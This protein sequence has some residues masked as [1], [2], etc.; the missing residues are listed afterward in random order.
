MMFRLLLLVLWSWVVS[1]TAAQ[2]PNV[3]FI[4]VD[5]LG[6]RDLGYMGSSYYETPNID[7]LAQEGMVFTQAYAGAANC[8]P[9]RACLLSGMNTPRHGIYTVGNSDRGDTRTRKVIPASNQTVLADSIYTLAELFRGQGYVTGTFGKWHLGDNPTTQGFDVNAGGSH[10]GNPGKNGYF[11]PY[12]VDHLPD[13]PEGEYLTDRLTSEAIGFLQANQE[14]P[15]FLYLPYYT[16]H[17]PIIGKKELVER[18]DKKE[19][20][21]GQDNPIYAA[22]TASLDENVGRLLTE[23]DRLQLRSN[24]IVVFTSDNGGIRDIS[25][26]DPL[27]A[28]KGSYYEG[29]I[30]V[31]LIIHWPEKITPQTICTTPVSN[32]DFY[33]TFQSILNVQSEE[34]QPLDGVDITPLLLGK[35]ITERPLFWHF[36]I[37]L[38]A[39]HPTEDGGR[40]P[41]FR[42]RPGSVVRLGEWKLHHYYEDD[43]LELYN[44]NKDLGETTNVA[45]DYP[46]VRNKLYQLLTNWF[47]SHQL[48][49]SFPKNPDYDSEFEQQQ[50]TKVLR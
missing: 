2:S 45:N 27:R 3:V 11:S 35:E 32:L 22:M 43:S 49:L 41:L 40:D 31:P 17:T 21:H 38:Q 19:T 16:V 7:R 46:D 18:F 28:G 12:N 1:E 37:Y 36:P 33:P 23:I 4:N 26:Q 25:Y 5:D 34:E 30:R 24:T 9:S 20:T 8:A 48:D 6:Y 15:F 50:K 42:T 44:L 29:G 14:K 47:K 13:G 39:Y 10:R